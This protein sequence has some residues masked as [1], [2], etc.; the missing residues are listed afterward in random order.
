MVQVLIMMFLIMAILYMLVPFIITRVCGWGVLT[1]G[2]QVN[3]IAFTFDDGP[4]PCYTPQLLDL[5]QAYRAKA[6]FF[7]I[8]SK[9]EAHPKLILRMHQEGHQIGIHN[10]THTSNW[11]LTPWSTKREQVDQTASIIEQIT[12]ERPIFYRPPW[13]LLNLG[14]FVWLRKCYEVTLWSVMVGDWK[15]SVRAEQIKR[16]LL[17]R[18]KPGSI[19]VLHDSGDTLGACE[20]S[21]RYM[22][23]ALEEVLEEIQSKGWVCLRTDELLHKGIAGVGKKA[24]KSKCPG[25]VS[26]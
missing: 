9:A 24:P 2:K 13:G 18:M 7:V 12:G 11:F 8:G 23:E 16:K 4:D 21:P 1:K 15:C 14:D 3:G 25:Q 26:L 22:I 5:L 10:Y 6:T 19:V 20:N 17:R